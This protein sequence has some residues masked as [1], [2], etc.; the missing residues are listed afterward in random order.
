MT[1]AHLYASRSSSLSEPPATDR[2]KRQIG[3]YFPDYR[4]GKGLGGGSGV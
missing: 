2:Q 3:W 4:G 1:A